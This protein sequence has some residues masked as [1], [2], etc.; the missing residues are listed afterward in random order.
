MPYTSVPERAV[1]T[2]KVRDV[3]YNVN[4]SLRLRDAW[5]TG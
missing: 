1:V 4:E 5:M 3:R 2:T